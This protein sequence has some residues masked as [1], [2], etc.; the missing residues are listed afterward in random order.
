ME[1]GSELLYSFLETGRMFL[2][3]E[4]KKPILDIFMGNDFFKCNKRTLKLWS[5]IIDWVVTMDKGDLFTEMLNKVSS[6]SFI[7]SR[8]SETK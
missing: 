4:L 5:K 6:F 8:D 1:C 7:F 2:I 3:K